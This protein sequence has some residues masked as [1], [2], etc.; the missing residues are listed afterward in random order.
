MDKVINYFR[1]MLLD[2]PASSMPISIIADNPIDQPIADQFTKLM[3]FEQ[4]GAHICV[5]KEAQEKFN[6]LSDSEKD[7]CAEIMAQCLYE[8]QVKIIQQLEEQAK[9]KE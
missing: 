4:Y 2:M 9:I 8:T 3:G 7:C 1:E 6:A 5:S